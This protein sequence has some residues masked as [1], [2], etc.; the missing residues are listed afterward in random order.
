MA[1]FWGR[2]IHDN[3]LL[4]QE[5]VH[6]LNRR[7]HGNNFVLKLD[8]AKAYDMMSWSFIFQMLWSLGFLE[9][10]ISSIY[11][12]ISGLWYSI[13]VNGS[14]HSFFQSHEAYG[15]AILY[16]CVFSLLQLSF[17]PEVWIPFILGTLP[18]H[19]EPR[20]L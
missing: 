17:S 16:P 1:S 20:S 15:R 5:L 14:C 18:W 3:I 13:M 12:V 19:I 10:W 11:R 9:R 4:V 6:D 7:T 8:M 2:V